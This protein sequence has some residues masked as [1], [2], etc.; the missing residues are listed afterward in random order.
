MPGVR[1]AV[2]AAVGAVAGLYAGGVAGGLIGAGISSF[3]M[4]GGGLETLGPAVVGLVVGAGAG[5]AAG[6]WL[7]LRFTAADAA[8]LT[9][10]L[11]LPIMVV[12]AVTAQLIGT[13][14]FAITSVVPALLT[15]LAAVI[16]R[17]AV[18]GLRSRLASG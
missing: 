6:C 16:A 9:A 2:T 7:A 15:A 5:A 12:T 1:H 17:L 8:G 10:V 4:I 14:A 13:S 18:L 3:V 11:L